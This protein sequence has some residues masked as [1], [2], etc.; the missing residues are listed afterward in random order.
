MFLWSQLSQFLASECSS[1]QTIGHWL[2]KMDFWWQHLKLEL[3]VKTEP[4]SWCSVLSSLKWQNTSL[5]LSP[6]VLPELSFHSVDFHSQY[7]FTHE[8]LS[9]SSSSAVKFVTG[10]YEIVVF[11]NTFP[12]MHFLHADLIHRLKRCKEKTHHSCIYLVQVVWKSS[13]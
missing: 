6:Q 10:F 2:K 1:H 11:L 12:V 8:N 3:Q 5:C 9:N 13:H 4:S 7:F